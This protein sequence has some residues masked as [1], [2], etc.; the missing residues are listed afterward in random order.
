[1]MLRARCKTI[2]DELGDMREARKREAAITPFRRRSAEAG[3]DT[4]DKIDFCVPRS[5]IPSSARVQ[6]CFI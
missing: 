6:Y 2:H 1:M 3:R 5:N 4:L